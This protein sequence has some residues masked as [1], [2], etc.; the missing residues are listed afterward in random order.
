MAMPRAHF[1]VVE[2]EALIPALERIFVQVLQLR[3]GLRALGQKLDRAGVKPNVEGQVDADL[4]AGPLAVRQA[5]AVFRG[6]DEALSDEIERVR[7]LGGEVK[8]IDLGL[9]DFPSTRNG[10][11]ILLCWKLGEK[12][13]GYWHAVDGG[14]AS[15][16]PIDA[17]ISSAPSRLD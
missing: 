1:T 13:L 10:E 5:K 7:A 2:V 6:L 11:E 4:E 9:V 8:D 3:A 16:R 17:Q 14:F 15:R 12:S